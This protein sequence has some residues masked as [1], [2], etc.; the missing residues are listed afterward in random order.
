MDE[1]TALQAAT[2]AGGFSPC[3]KSKRGVVIWSTND[4]SI[5][6]FGWNHPPEPQYCDGSSSCRASCGKVAVHAEQAALLQCRDLGRVIRGAEML[7]T[8][9]VFEDGKW[10]SVPGGPPSCPDCS[11]LM[12]EAG[13]DGVW[14]VEERD[15]NSTLVRYT[16]VE[17]HHQTLQNCGLHPYK[18]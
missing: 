13:I 12:L 9:V 18:K 15:G 4:P 16:A 7:H 14:L 5:I 17:F 1:N 6:G 8:K 10:V 11:K 3:G 2:R